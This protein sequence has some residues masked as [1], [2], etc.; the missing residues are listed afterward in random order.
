[1]PMNQPEE[2]SLP[3]STQPPAAR[4]GRLYVVGIGPGH[5]L[6]RTVRACQVLQHAD[7]IVGYSKYIPLVQDL[8]GGTHVEA[9]GAQEEA[10][11]CRIA[12]ERACAG[13]IVALLSAGDPGVYGTAGVLLDLAASIPA[14]PPIEIIPGMTAATAAAARFGT[15]LMLDCAFLNLNDTLVSWARIEKR[16][17]AIGQG[18]LVAVFYNPRSST[19]VRPF[20]RACEILLQYR[21]A[22][23][24]VGIGTAVGLPDET[25]R[26]TE[27]GA[28][29]EEAVGARSVVIVGESTS[30]VLDGW[31]VTPR[32]P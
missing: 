4:E 5:P 26:M 29:A 21:P 3:E 32:M 8:I 27:L 11:R 16:L 20:A 25:L 2:S 18:D 14:R 31:F 15:P 23:T 12:L 19:R 1:M 9:S 17:H 13:R 6:D 28:L 7:L 30:R 22:T 10:K 24:P